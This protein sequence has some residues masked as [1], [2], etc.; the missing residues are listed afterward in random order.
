MIK[1]KKSL[2]KDEKLERLSLS[3]RR[4]CC[5]PPKCMVRVANLL[6]LSMPSM[7][8]TRQNRKLRQQML[9]LFL[10]FGGM[11]PLFFCSLL[12]CSTQAIPLKAEV[13]LF[14]FEK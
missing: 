2:M 6:M 3:S 10:R 13:D 9:T 5:L 4:C 1:V 7:Q 8:D 14:L 12:A 11:L